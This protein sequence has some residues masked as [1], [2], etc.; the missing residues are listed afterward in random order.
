MRIRRLDLTRFGKFTDYVIDFGSRSNNGPDIHV[1]Y[2]PNESAKST[3][4]AAV[5]DLLFGIETRSS[6]GFLH[7]Y[8]T[9]RLGADVVR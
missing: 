1:V 6:Y 8:P 2:G 5:L 9:M 7:P 3:T 4:L